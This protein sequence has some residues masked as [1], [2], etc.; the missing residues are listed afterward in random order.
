[1]LNKLLDNKGIKL[2][3]HMEDILK[4]KELVLEWNKKFNLTAITEDEEFDIKHLYDCLLLLKLDEINKAKTI[5][6]V[7]TGAGFPG[8]VLAICLPETQF[9]L[10]DSVNKK[11]RFLDLVVEELG[12]KNVKTI[13]GRSEELA[14]D[15]LYRDNFDICVS[16]AVASLDTLTEYCL[17]L[18][19]KDGYFISMKGSKADEELDQAENAIKLLSA[20]FEKKIDYS[21]A[22]DDH[23]R[24]LIFLKKINTTGKKYPR[25]AGA[26][27]S[28]PL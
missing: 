24:S 15:E 26:P 27:R 6:D 8:I 21:L 18:V 9:T 10:V 1:M 2:D 14:R 5:V 23:N 25:A 13:H 7:G 4:Y 11:V 20:K 19:K 17:P 3:D 16:R 22:E 12:L 28:K